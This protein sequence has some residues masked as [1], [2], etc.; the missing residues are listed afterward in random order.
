MRMTSRPLRCDLEE[1]RSL[2]VPSI[3]HWGLDH[4]VVLIKVKR[5]SIIIQD[6]ATGTRTLSFK[7][8]G[9]RFTGV[10]LELS[11]APAFKK[12]RESSPLKL[13]S[14][15]RA[16]PTIVGG[17]GQVLILSL[18]LQ[19][20]V[21]ASPF[22]MQLAIDEA[23][24]KGDSGLLT[25]LAIGFGLFGLFNVGATALRGVALQKMSA[26]LGWDMTSRLF[27]QML[28]LPLPWFQR[29][30]LADALTR[31]ESIEPVRAL[32]ANG[33]VGS[34]IDGLL[35]VVTLVMM[36]VFAWP[37]A[38]VAIAGLAFYVAIRLIAIPWSIRLGGE[39]LAASIAEQ[40]KRIETLRAIQTI[41]VMG[42]E[43]RRE[44]DWANK[45]AETIRTGQTNAFVSIGFSSLQGVADAVTNVAIIYLGAKA[46][47][48]NTM[49][50]GVL[51]AFMAYKAQFLAR[52]QGLFETFV[53]WRMLD[54]HSERLADIALTP[55]EPGL[56]FS[57]VGLPEMKGEIELRNLSFRYSPQDPL[58]IHA[59]N[60]RIGHGEFVAIAGPSGAGKSTLIKVL[61]GL[62][63]ASAGDVLI[64]GLPISRWG[65]GP[66]RRNLGVV[67][68]DDELVSGSIAEN[69]AFFDEQID[70]DWLWDCLATAAIANEIRAMPMRAETFVGDMGSAL[71]G[72]QKQ[73]IL[74]ARAL[75]RRPKILILD[76]ATSHLDVALERGIN[77]ALK[78]Q[79]I[80]RLVVAH[81]PETIAAA[82][83]VLVLSD[84][85][86]VEAQDRRQGVGAADRAT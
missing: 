69:V 68:Q 50:V 60:A 54:I 37:L 40:G 3:L 72:G 51:Y 30:R 82:D 14:L 79:T 81:R 46:I 6:P 76:E 17:L 73:R 44:G 65:P 83:R 25:A 75:Y 74:L 52:G 15:F 53:N 33:L 2:R 49:S 35:T 1:L 4:F 64:D 56:D 34:V 39:A 80:T 20:Y 31:F 12:R 21:V 84:S 57:G 63:P 38:M 86:L 24:L 61:C 36:F 8:A 43:T 70:M 5:H 16:T 77:A 10:A 18:L 27:H 22:Y 78:S 7:E 29:R 67:L 23:A 55:V 28:R 41:K 19:A 26:L 42:A 59:A 71:S 45:F 58:V 13:T 85:R 32:F 47:I 11:P 9:L 48:D 62:Y 66:V